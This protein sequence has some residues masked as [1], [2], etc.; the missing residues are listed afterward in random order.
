MR[1]YDVTEL[2]TTITPDDARALMA[3][4]EAN[5]RFRPARGN[6]YAEQMEAGE[7]QDN[8]STIAVASTGRVL[9]GQHRL[10]ACIQS[11][12][13]FRA[14]VVTGLSLSTMLTIDTGKARNADDILSIFGYTNTRDLAA[15]AR[16][17]YNWD[18]GLTQP[19]NYAVGRANTPQVL[20]TVEDH[21][22]LQ[23][24]VTG[25]TPNIPGLPKSAYFFLRWLLVNVDRDWTHYYFRILQGGAV[26]DP[27]GHPIVSLRARLNQ[28][29]QAPK[30][31]QQRGKTLVVCLK[32]WNV[33][34]D[35]GSLRRV[36]YRDGDRLQVPR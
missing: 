4:H 1:S 5:R 26:D 2:T 15:L 14:I 12:T 19:S 36:D 13:P 16:S 34:R 3:R 24:F 28:I 31:G 11:N 7:W 27:E 20:K 8:A 32:A 30:S 6:Q 10:T 9:D 23:D 18:K 29:A 21:P 22:E 17:V 35:G 33:W 25:P